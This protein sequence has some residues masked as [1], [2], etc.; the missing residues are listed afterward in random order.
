MNFQNNYEYV[1]YSFG[2]TRSGKIKWI[3]LGLICCIL[4]TAIIAIPLGLIP[5][6]LKSIK[7]TFK[8]F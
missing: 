1:T 8:H 2:E 7:L 4:A 5:I 3:I 6:Y